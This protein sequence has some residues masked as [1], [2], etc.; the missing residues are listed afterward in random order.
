M[1]GR[2]VGECAIL[3]PDRSMLERPSDE[4]LE[5]V[6]SLPAPVIG[7]AE[8]RKSARFPCVAE[9][10]CTPFDAEQ[11]Q[12]GEPFIAVSRDVSMGGVS[13]FHTRSAPAQYLLVRL[14]RGDQGPFQVLV[15]VLGCD[16]LKQF[17]QYRGRFVNRVES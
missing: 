5:F 16:R 12:C 2:S 11:R 6:R 3:E 17:V 7:A 14:D 10:L 1:A 15:E 4:L 8:N 13:V 9:I